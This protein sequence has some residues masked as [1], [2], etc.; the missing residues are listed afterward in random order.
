MYLLQ[1]LAMINTVKSI[2]R[3][4]IDRKSPA[5]TFIALFVTGEKKSVKYN[6]RVNV[7]KSL[8]ASIS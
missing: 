7:K 4:N 8:L 1:K 2:A 6:R 5:D 3:Q